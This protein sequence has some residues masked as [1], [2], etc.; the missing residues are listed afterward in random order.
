MKNITKY[1]VGCIAVC[2][3]FTFSGCEDAEYDALKDQAFILQ[4]NTNPNSS[5]KLTIGSEPVSTEINVRLSDLASEKS[6]YELV[7]DPQALEAYNLTNQTPYEA[8][9]EG[10]YSLSTSELTVET[11]KS[12]SEPVLLTI[13]PFSPEL[14]SSGKKYAVPLRLVKKGGNTSVL[15]SG[16]VII[17]VLDQVVIQPVPVFNRN[18]FPWIMYDTPFEVNDWTVEF[19]VNMSKLGKK[20]HEYN[21][22]AVFDNYGGK[23]YVRFGDAPIEGNRLQ[24]V[25]QGTRLASKL[26]FDEKKWYHVAFVLQGTTLYFYINGQLDS[27]IGAAGTPTKMEGWRQCGSGRYFVADAMISELRI[28]S[29]ART[30]AEIQN[31]MYACDPNTDGLIGYWKYNEGEGNILHDSSKYGNHFEAHGGTP[32][33]VQN[34]RIDGK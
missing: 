8:L 11:G 5:K 27:S 30:Q 26:Q 1:L 24:I 13:K 18:V 34:V 23:I 6:T 2:G 14:Q 31:N 21:N 20:I 17:Y 9:P 32:G 4:T 25:T 15:S 16:S 33:W 19:N 28:W 10:A 7:S 22:Q 3:M 29:K 12:V